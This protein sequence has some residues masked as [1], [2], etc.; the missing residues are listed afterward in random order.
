MIQQAL[1]SP[2][3]ALF[4]HLDGAGADVGADGARRAAPTAARRTR[5]PRPTSTERWP[6]RPG[7]M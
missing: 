4:E 2:A 3:A 5:G 7:P 6:G 1:I